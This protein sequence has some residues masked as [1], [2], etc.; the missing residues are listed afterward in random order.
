M[1]V[2]IVTPA[3]RLPLPIE[4][5]VYFVVSEALTNAARYASAARSPSA[6]GIN[7]GSWRSRCAT[8]ESVA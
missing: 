6:F 5:A 1:P 7:L 3:H 4:S 8:T 2:A